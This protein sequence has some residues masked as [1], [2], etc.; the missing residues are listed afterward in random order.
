MTNVTEV[1]Q[2]AIKAAI[3]QHLPAHVGEVLQA[4]LQALKTER[5]SHAIT[6]S[7][8]EIETRKGKEMAAELA[9]LYDREKAAAKI[10]ERET[11]VGIRE[12]YQDLRDLEVKLADLRR[13]DAVGLVEMVFRSP[14][15]TRAVASSVPIAVEGMPASQYGGGTPGFVQTHISTSTETASES[16]NHRGK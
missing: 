16:Q 6:K 3:L 1:T 8:L 7:H 4:E 11:A 5:T 13:S 9:A 10:L 2:D 12:K 15:F 14:V